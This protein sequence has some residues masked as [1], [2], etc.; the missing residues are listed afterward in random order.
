MRSAFTIADIESD[1]FLSRSR[2]GYRLH[3]EEHAIPVALANDVLRLDGAA[4]DVVVAT[5][6]DLVHIHL[7][8]ET[9]TVRYTDPVKRHAGHGAGSA[10]DVTE[11]P[12]PGTVVAVNAAP[13]Q[14]VARG[15]TLLVIE[16]MKLETAIKAWRDGVVAA[17]NVATGQTFDRGAP[18]VALE[19]EKAT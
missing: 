8:G 5:D 15:E 6:G 9:H 14:S 13:G 19:P 3:I 1:V 18:L 2:D 12:M 4:H 10:D 7:D 11:A 17:V 16:S